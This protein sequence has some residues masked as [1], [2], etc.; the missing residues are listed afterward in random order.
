MIGP[1]KGSEP[2]LRPAAAEN[3]VIS[4][5]PKRLES[6]KTGM[7]NHSGAGAG[8]QH[9]RRRD[10]ERG[11]HDADDHAIAGAVQLGN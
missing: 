11:H 4:Q 2:E 6:A 10:D 7:L 3:A 1:P 5:M 8:T 9:K